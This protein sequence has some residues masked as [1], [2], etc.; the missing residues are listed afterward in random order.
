MY[1]SGAGAVTA[2]VGPSGAGK[3]T[4]ARLVPRLWEPGGGSVALGGVDVRELPLD[5]LLARIAV[6][7]QEVFLF[8]GTVRENLLLA[9]PDATE[10][11]ISRACRAARA[12]A[13]TQSWRGPS[14]VVT[15]RCDTFAEGMAT[16]MSYDLTFDILKRELNDIVTLEEEELE[17]GVRLAL[18]LTHN[19]AEGAGA[20]SLAA[21]S[22]I[23]ERLK[24]KKV[25][26]VMSGGNIDKRTLKRIL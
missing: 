21:A 3:T 11:E 4:I 9:K 8:H 15:D 1:C 22:K 6:V 18:S 5:T 25:V 16:R 26:C 19:L 23:R 24:G 14:R 7:F 13:F 17:E 20:A 12:D 2:L 10:E